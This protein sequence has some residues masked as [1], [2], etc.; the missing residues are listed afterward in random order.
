MEGKGGGDE[1][2]SLGGGRVRLRPREDEVDAKGRSLGGELA[3]INLE[4]GK[5]RGIK[6]HPNGCS[7]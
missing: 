6:T 1:A 5:E 3:N 2:G 7:C 4:A